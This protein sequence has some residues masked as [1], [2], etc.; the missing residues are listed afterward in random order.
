MYTMAAKQ[1]RSGMTRCRPPYGG[2]DGAGSK[3]AT[4][5]HSS[6]GTRSS[7]SV[8][9]ARDHARPTQGSETT[10]YDSSRSPGLVPVHVGQPVPNGL[11]S[12]RPPQPKRRSGLADPGFEWQKHGVEP[13]WLGMEPAIAQRL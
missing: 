3:G 10:S 13:C 12:G 7:A 11:E 4:S 9:M 5:A 2:R 1:A 6:S 8:V